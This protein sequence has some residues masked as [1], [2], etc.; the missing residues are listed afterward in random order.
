[1]ADE[2]DAGSRLGPYRI[3]RP[4]GRGGMGVVYEGTD[5]QGRPVAIKV[6]AR[7]LRRDPGF[8]ARFEREARSASRVSHPCV[9][10]FRD[11]GKRGGVPYLVLEWVPGGTLRGLVEREGPLEW[12]RAA[13]LLAKVADGLA[14]VH[15]AGIIH[16]DLKPEN[17]LLDGA[18]QPK[19]ADLGLSRR[20]SQSDQSRMTAT[21]E[22]VGTPAYMAP[23]QVDGV[24]EIDARADVYG[25]GAT[26]FFAITGHAPFQGHGWASLA[27]HFESPPPSLRSETHVPPELDAFAARLLARAPADRP[28]SAEVARRLEEIAASAAGPRSTS[29]LGVVVVASLAVVAALG[30]SSWLVDRRHERQARRDAADRAASERAR[31][32]TRNADDALAALARGEE[33]EGLAR[34][35]DAVAAASEAIPEVEALDPDE[36]SR[37]RNAQA[38][39][40]APAL[41]RALATRV[42]ARPFVAADP[43]RSAADLQRAASVAPDDPLVHVA[44]GVI[45]L[46]RR[47]LGTALAESDLAGDVPA[48]HAVAAAALEQSERWEEAAR[49]A[50]ASGWPR[51]ELAAGVDLLRAGDAKRAAE[52]LDRALARRETDEGLLARAEAARRLDDAAGAKQLLER[53]LA[54]APRSA[55]AHGGRAYWALLEGDAEAAVSHARAAVAGEPSDPDLHMILARALDL[56]ADFDAADKEARE[57]MATAER[58]GDGS[59]AYEAR[60]LVAALATSRSDFT[61]GLEVLQDADRLAPGRP[62]APARIAEV[63]LRERRRAPPAERDALLG[64]AL[65]WASKAIA[66][67]TGSAEAL[68]VEANALITQAQAAKATPP[69]EILG[70]LDRAQALDP[71]EGETYLL[72]ARYWSLFK[73]PAAPKERAASDRLAIAALHA[74]LGMIPDD[75]VPEPIRGALAASRRSLDHVFHRSWFARAHQLRAAA[76]TSREVSALPQ[77]SRMLERILGDRAFHFV[78]GLESALVWAETARSE[79]RSHNEEMARQTFEQRVFPLLASLYTSYPTWIEPI[80]CHASL[81]LE[82]GDARMAIDDLEQAKQIDEREPRV[83]LLLAQARLTTG[84]AE[85]ALREARRATQLKPDLGPAW[86]A[87]A[88][89]LHALGREDEAREAE[90]RASGR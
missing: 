85:G 90:R 60:L 21:G 74:E 51:L 34:A 67:G 37:R 61:V 4:V 73:D 54:I 52:L 88:R 28:A 5:E 66:R 64:N 48:A 84:D 49:R 35:D 87:T 38:H 40:V 3:V 26:L 17:V 31:L 10:G 11:V 83:F 58:G 86:I 36:A 9:V 14:A 12:S 42:M 78:A 75:Q 16:R 46:G 77:S 22:V 53:A 20:A 50:I 2:L 71:A 45:A 32:V 18:G 23:E 47:D 19:L 33:R 81:Q 24:K 59:V 68:R 6:V 7:E 89:A 82:F 79:L 29:R 15:A 69:S 41:V 76:E 44:R 27:Q 63:F 8:L 80:I 56:A 62:E 72:R 13:A 39:A 55:R 57:A 25:L 43:E 1:V 70:L 30:A 65:G